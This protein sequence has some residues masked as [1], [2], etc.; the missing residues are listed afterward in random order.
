[1]YPDAG[2]LIDL[3][4]SLRAVNKKQFQEFLR[5]SREG[6]SP[7]TMMILKKPQRADIERLQ[8]WAREVVGD[9]DQLF[10]K[11]VHVQE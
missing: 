4:T 10:M 5:I 8:R 9:S 3:K 11:I 2:K 7:L 1:M 6:Q